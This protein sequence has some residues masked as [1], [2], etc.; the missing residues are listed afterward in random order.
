[1]SEPAPAIFLSYARDDVA[2]ARRIAEALR[3]SGLEVWFDE[4]ELRGGDAWDQSIRQHIRDCALFVPIVSVHTQARREGYFRLEWKLADERTHLMAEGTPFVLPVAIDDTKERDALVPKSFLAAQW[5]RLSATQ[6]TTQLVARIGRLLAAASSAGITAPPMPMRPAT[7]RGEGTAPPAP[8][9]GRRGPAAAW[10]GL[11]AVVA[12][13]GVAVF[14]ATRKAEPSTA[15]APALSSSNPPAPAAS[16][17]SDKSIAV[18]L[19]TNL[20][21]EKDNEFFADGVH[22]D[23]LTNLATVPELKVVSRTTVTQYR[24]SK[25]SM[26]QIGEELGV[27]YI[28]EGS[29]RRAGNKVRVTGQ[30]I[31]ARTDEHVWAKSYD[32]DLTN[33]FAIQSS[34]AQEIASA[35]QVVL[36]PH[37]QKFIERRPTENPVAY[38][39]FLKG[40]D[41]RNR[42]S[43]NRLTSLQQ[44]EAQF[45]SAVERDPKFAAAWGELAVV[46]AK[47]VFQAHDASAERLARADAAIANAAR[48]APE[49]PD[50]IRLIGD[51]AYYARRDYAQAVAQYEKLARLQPNDPTVYHSFGLIQRRQGKWAEAL[52]NLRRSVELDPGNAGY[53][54]TLASTFIRARRGEEAVATQ[55]RL[56]VLLPDDLAEQI[57]LTGYAFLVTGSD[58]EAGDLIARLTP[59]QLASPRVI[60]WRRSRAAATGDY[61]EFKRLDALQ[62][63]SDG[64]GSER[65]IPATSA[66]MVHAVHGDRP[67]ARTRL[68]DFPA[69]VRSRI[70]REPA[71]A[72][73]YAYLGIME[74][75]LEHREEA[76]RLALKAT[77][78][79]PE[80]QD[81]MS[82]AGVTYHA[83]VIHAWIGDKDRALAELAHLLRVPN[84]A[85]SSARAVRNNSWWTP[86]HG[87]PR[88]E[89]LLAD[90]KNNAPLF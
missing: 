11:A 74:A 16:K 84:T 62:P 38:D 48:L 21:E 55:R 59:V 50:V 54:R 22:E 23:I 8:E 20:S 2:A 7:V 60:S 89:A 29:V 37:A 27:A 14:F 70:Q 61:A 72:T 49:A 65:F 26:K 33:I 5:T 3:A 79:L 35:L 4:S 57:T 17:I 6:S 15:A 51:H 30:L 31:N 71:N 32:R 86:L 47:Y 12:I 52:A 1:M 83:A 34:L 63:F 69:E 44:E 80:S 87:D 19:F 78:L 68:G 25:K 82:G 45:Q 66:A 13:A 43:D 46:H 42:L 75:L 76:A 67:A 9:G 85:A 56:V 90:P 24:D 40:R 58:Q 64:N 39:A 18:L 28:L 88:F 73:L 10:I 77:E 41:L 53:T 81:A 36:T